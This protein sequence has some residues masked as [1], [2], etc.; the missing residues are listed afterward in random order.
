M[1]KLNLIFLFSIIYV[2]IVIKFNLITTKYNNIVSVTGVVTNIKYSND[3][4]TITIKNKEKI[5]IYTNSNIS[6]S[7]GDYINVTGKFYLPGENT[8]K[9]IFNYRNYLKSK[10]IFWITNNPEINIIKYNKNIFYKI[11]NKII[12][13]INNEYLNSFIL[14]DNGYLD[15]TVITSYRINGISHLF[16][17]SGMHITLLSTLL[18]KLLSKIFKSKKV[19]YILVSSF[20]IFYMFLIDFTPSVIRAVLLFIILN[21]TKNKASSALIIILSILLIIN[22]YYI[23]DLGFKYSFIV[24]FFLI[25]FNYLFN[26]NYFYNLILISLIA[27][28]A[29]IP[30]QINN[31]FSINLLTIINNIIFVPLVSIIIFPF[32]LLTFLLK[33]LIPVLDFLMNIFEHLSIF[34]SKF[35]IQMIIPKM[36]IFL[37]IIYYILLYNL[38]KI[39]FVIIVFFLFIYSNIKYFNPRCEVTFLDVGQGDS[40][41][42]SLPYNK[43]NILID[44]GGNLFSDKNYISNNITIPYLKSIGVK[45]LDYLIIT[46]GDADHAKEALNIINNIKVD[47]IL[48]NNYNNELESKLDGKNIDNTILNINGYK[49]RIFNYRNTI[50]NNDSLIVYTII[51]NYKLLFMGDATYLEEKMLL[52]DFNIRDIDI[53]KVGHHGSKTSSSKEF[54]EKLKPTYSIISVGENNMY[55]H[56]NEEVLKNLNASKIL[57]TD[58]SGTINFV[59]NKNK[60]KVITYKKQ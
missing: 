21:F 49:F 11:K 59:F 3:K 9:N 51:S 22:P 43:G 44:T 36:P 46:H 15:D 34:M 38:N 55:G 26:K 35:N 60:Y 30:I 6:L 37:I 48:L 41:F 2:F 56:P 27:F 25:R 32:S 47:R 18:L 28:L 20:L 52:E 39:N 19:I 5:L 14:G 24:S 8:T 16:S 57:R 1:K 42:I 40:I 29:S 58:L 45:K 17:I 10:K 12:H 7:L 4:T 23:Y 54:I 50:E 53:L 13:K 31:F 33:P